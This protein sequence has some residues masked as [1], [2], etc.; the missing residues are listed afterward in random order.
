MVFNN[1][2]AFENDGGVQVQGENYAIEVKGLA[3]QIVITGGLAVL[4]GLIPIYYAT[5]FSVDRN[6]KQKAYYKVH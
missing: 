2:V 6:E 1:N 5:G 3:L 4:Q